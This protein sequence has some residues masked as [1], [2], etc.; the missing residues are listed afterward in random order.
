MATVAGRT[1]RVAGQVC[2]PTD[3]LFQGAGFSRI[4]NGVSRAF[5]RCC[6]GAGVSVASLSRSAVLAAT[7]QVLCGP[8]RLLSLGMP[9]RDVAQRMPVFDQEPSE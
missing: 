3:C 1:K 4:S 6:S 8:V 2:S 7:G 9:A 5:R